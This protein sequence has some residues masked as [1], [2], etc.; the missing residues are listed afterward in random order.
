MKPPPS[1]GFPT[2]GHHQR[3]TVACFCES[4][5]RK[6]SAEETD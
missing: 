6:M 4:C 1:G 5:M 3:A 2:I